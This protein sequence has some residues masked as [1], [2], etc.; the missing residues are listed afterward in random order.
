MVN[1]SFIEK[2]EKKQRKTRKRKKIIGLLVVFLFLSLFCFYY[3]CGVIKRVVVD[4]TKAS[5]DKIIVNS[6]NFSISELLANE[7][8]DLERIV[9]SN[10][11]EKNNAIC[12]SVDAKIFNEVSSFLATKTE[13]KINFNCKPGILIPIGTLTGFAFLNG[14]GSNILF[15]CVPVGNIKC[16]IDSNFESAGINQTIHRLYINII[17]ELSVSLPIENYETSKEVSFLALENI[18]VGDVPLVFLN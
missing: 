1:E 16:E 13:E 18:L 8:I 17:A 7:N 4:I 11:D 2:F 14:K 10:K 9:V 5:V 6:I 3:Y 12:F 15:S